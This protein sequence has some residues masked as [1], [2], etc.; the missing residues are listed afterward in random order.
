MLEPTNIE[1]TYK[2]KTREKGNYAF[3]DYVL[4]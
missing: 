3:G 1:K 4:N 2:V